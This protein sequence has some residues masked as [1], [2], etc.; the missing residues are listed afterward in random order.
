MSEEPLTSQQARERLAAVDQFAAVTARRAGPV[1][2]VTTAGV[3]VLVA[4]ALAATYVTLPD[5]PVAFAVSF[6]LYGVA[7]AALMVWNHRRQ[8][9]AQHGFKKAYAA[10]FT[11]T[12]ALYVVGIATISIGDWPWPLAAL[13]CVAVAVPMVIAAVRMARGRP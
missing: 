5:H 7:L 12:M 13:Y 2:A 1:A 8:V 4:L 6:A 9:V 10:G 11:T 3:G